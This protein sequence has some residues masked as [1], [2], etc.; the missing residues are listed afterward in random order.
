MRSWARKITL[1]QK[2]VASR[3]KATPG[4][5]NATITPARAGPAI[6]PVLLVIPRSPFACCRRGGLT[7]LG[8]RPVAAGWQKAS[9][10]P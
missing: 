5:E 10:A 1:T 4:S 2:V 6:H 7:V 3:A 8:T 9:A